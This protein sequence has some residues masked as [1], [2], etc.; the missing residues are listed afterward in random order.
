MP[1]LATPCLAPPYPATPPCSNALRRC[2][3][4]RPADALPS[5]LQT[6]ST[7]CRRRR[8]RP[9]VAEGPGLLPADAADLPPTMTPTL[10]RPA[11]AEGPSLLPADADAD[12]DS[13]ALPCRS[14]TAL[15]VFGRSR[16]VGRRCLASGTLHRHRCYSPHGRADHRVVIL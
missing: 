2:P 7:C 10:Y 1:C 15:P 13:D 12:A 3:A 11:V 9:A 16:L 6:S 8:R 4:F 14:A 5:D